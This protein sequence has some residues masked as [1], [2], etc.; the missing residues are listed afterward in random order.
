MSCRRTE[1][2]AAS[3][4][5]IH[6]ILLEVAIQVLGLAGLDSSPIKCKSGGMPF[7]ASSDSMQF[8][9]VRSPRMC[10]NDSGSTLAQII[11]YPTA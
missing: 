11:N 4:R 5:R 3:L 8:S 9:R 1:R 10:V 7:S 2:I 6:S